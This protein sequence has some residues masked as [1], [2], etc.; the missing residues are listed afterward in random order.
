M[1]QVSAYEPCAAAGPGFTAG[2]R[3]ERGA[4]RRPG[5]APGADSVGR[6]RRGVLQVSLSQRDQDFSSEAT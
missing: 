4:V 1:F 2:L 6:P 5:V 3:A